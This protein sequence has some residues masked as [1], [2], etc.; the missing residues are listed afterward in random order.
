MVIASSPGN[1]N[2]C[3]KRQTHDITYVEEV[4]LNGVS[5]ELVLVPEGEFVMGSPDDEEARESREGPQHSV[6]VSRFWMGQY[7]ITQAQWRIVA[8]Y[9]RVN[10]DLDPDP[11]EFKGDLN[12]VEQVSWYDAVEFCDRLSQRTGRNYRL[13]TEAEWEYACRA[14]TTTPFHFG[15]TLSAQYS[16]YYA[17]ETYGPGEV[18][19]FRE[20]TT[21]IDYFQIGNAFGLIDIHGNVWEW[22]LDHWHENYEKA[23]TDG[24]AWLTNEEKTDRIVRG[25]SW[26]S[27]P[28][29]CRS[30]TRYHNDPDYTI[31]NLGFR[32]VLASR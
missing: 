17:Q 6:K 15:A 18:G 12:P 9:E 28:R 29:Y 7:P 30:A 32:I 24:S 21:P 2:I 4:L 11:S 1:P 25:G 27:D 8:Q 20:K 5:L 31:Y 14:G 16:N 19:E 13:P 10:R 22:C 23:P 26:Y 3:I